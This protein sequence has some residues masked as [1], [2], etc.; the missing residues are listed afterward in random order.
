MTVSGR[1]TPLPERGDPEYINHLVV[2]KA[3][4]ASIASRLASALG[5]GLNTSTNDDREI[6]L[7]TDN[8]THVNK[9][10]T[11]RNS[12]AINT[13][14]EMSGGNF[15]SAGAFDL[16]ATA[17]RGLSSRRTAPKP[18]PAFK[19][20]DRNLASISDKPKAETRV[21]KKKVADP[22]AASSSVWPTW[23]TQGSTIEIYCKISGKVPLG[24][25]KFTVL[26]VTNK[27][28]KT[29]L[30]GGR[31]KISVFPGKFR[32]D[33]YEGTLKVL[34]KSIREIKVSEPIFLPQPP[35]SDSAHLPEARL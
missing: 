32:Y 10:A 19:M 14:K 24:W 31:N 2:G 8:G 11:A 28:A 15:L 33:G 16:P 4:N 35:S 6:E 18:Q 13:I 25:H 9:S 34:H 5:I 27:S 30:V 21:S 26:A 29:Q 17:L 20:Y 1:G 12:G 22:P 7:R 3:M 23:L